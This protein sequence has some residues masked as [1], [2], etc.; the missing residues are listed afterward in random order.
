MNVVICG[1]GEVGRHA[2][3]VLARGANNVTVVDLSAQ[4]LAALDEVLD[5]RSLLGNGTQA[6]VLIEAGCRSADL[7]IAAT[8]VDEINLL[9]ASIA[10][11]VG[12]DKCI[13]RVH[14]AVYFDRR[15]IDY[16]AHL[17]IDHLVCPEYS[18]AIAIAAALR[19][20]GALAIENFARGRIE[21][22]Q[23]PVSPGAPAVGV[24]LK[25]LKLPSSTRL[26]AIDRAGGAFLPQ[27]DTT[28]QADDIITLIGET[29]SFEKARR[30]FYT[31]S[32]RRRRI[33]ILGGTG[34]SVWLCRALKDSGLSIRLFEPEAERAEELAEK[35][36]WVTVLKA[37]AIHTDALRDER[38][39]QADAFIALT[40]DDEQN[41]LAAARAKSMGCPTAIAVLQ[42]GTYL[43]LLD[44]V[45][46][47][48]AFSP[49]VTA[50]NEILRLLE[51]GPIRDLATLSE[52]VLEVYEIQVPDTAT[53]LVDRALR[54]IRFPT[55]LIIAAIQRGEDTVF[56]PGADSH[57]RAGDTM[58]VI[59]APEAQKKLR[60]MLG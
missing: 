42:R 43:H 23:I 20:P 60:R 29:E 52:G 53:A 12:A 48:R 41:I 59:A 21:M 37:D 50:V 10:K 40:N 33:I 2:A 45:G 13:A 1:A 27:A 14:H 31:S 35:L 36:G 9:A 15:G 26:A 54:D 19:S 56:V 47:D 51:P 44:F 34:Q 22:Q 4:K 7:F 17:G 8:N 57:I 28:V 55:H 38:V 6:D 3:E 24:M 58:I 39:D 30:L 18:T 5:V 25:D 16:A 32:D 49:R 11:G 46:I